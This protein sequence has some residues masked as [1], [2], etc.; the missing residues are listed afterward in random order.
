MC[1]IIRGCVY[2]MHTP[3]NTIDHR[4]V[5]H[6]S[7]HAS[8]VLLFSKWAPWLYAPPANDQR[9]RGSHNYIDDVQSP[10]ACL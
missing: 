6:G 7:S 4:R 3:G 5:M 1:H 10:Q 8:R 9:A 2:S